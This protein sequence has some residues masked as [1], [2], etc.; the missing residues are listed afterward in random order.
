MTCAE[1]LSLSI[2]YSSV[3]VLICF[4]ANVSLMSLNQTVLFS[5]GINNLK[6]WVFMS[7]TRKILRLASLPSCA[8]F[9]GRLGRCVS[10]VQTLAVV[11]IV[12]E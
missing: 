7:H 6:E 4:E 9:L 2:N 11:I 5:F 10:V 8:S 1:L 12:Y 3:S